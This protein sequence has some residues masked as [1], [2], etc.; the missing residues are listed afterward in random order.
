MFVVVTLGN[1]EN[2]SPAVTPTAPPPAPPPSRLH[3]SPCSC[4]DGTEKIFVQAG[5]GAVAC[6]YLLLS[7]ADKEEMLC[8]KKL[9]IWVLRGKMHVSVKLGISF[10]TLPSESYDNENKVSC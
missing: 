9:L 8:L 1:G 5:W 7:Y 3:P 2:P 4:F 10:Q 6:N